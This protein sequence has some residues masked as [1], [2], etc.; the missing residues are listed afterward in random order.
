HVNVSSINLPRNPH[1]EECGKIATRVE[2]M[3]APGS[4]AEMA[5]NTKVPE[6]QRFTHLYVDRGKPVDD[7]PRVRRRVAA[8]IYEIHDFEKLASIV[9]LELGLDV[10]W[11]A[12]GADWAVFLRQIK[13]RDLLDL[14]TLAF[15][16]LTAQK[17]LL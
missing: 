6:G 13:I 7:S 1:W 5:K 9:P 17:R 16:Y 4:N 14:I 15:R 10:P 8:L 12:M 11:I 3:Q 2:K